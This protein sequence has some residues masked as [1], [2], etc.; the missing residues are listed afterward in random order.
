M[1]L[2]FAGLLGLCAAAHAH[3][4]ADARTD[5]QQAFGQ[6]LDAGGFRARAQGHWFGPGAPA[7]SGEVDVIFPDRIHAVSDDMEFIALPDRAWV[8]A[9]GFWTATDRS[10]LPVTSFDP[11]AMR[12]AI[13]SIRDA[14]IEGSSKTAQCAAHVYRFRARGQLPGASADG[15]IRAWLCDAGHRIA[16]L[17][18]TDT[19]SNERVVLDFDWSHR[20]SVQAPSD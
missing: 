8:K 5:L 12:R 2:V 10:M 18:A 4:D 20:A 16:R 17:E 19:R 15:D 11:P 14:R 13:A 9:L 1:K 6:V 3:A 7:M